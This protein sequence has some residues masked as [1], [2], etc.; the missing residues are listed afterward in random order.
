MIRRPH[1]LG[2]FPGLPEHIDWHPATR[3]KIATDAKPFRLDE[4]D[5]FFADSD[6][7]ILMEDAITAKAVEVKR[8]GLRLHEPAPRHVIDNKRGKIRLPG[9][10]A[11]RGE[12]RKREAR[13]IIGVRMRI[14]HAIEHRILR[15]C[16][17]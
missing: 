3:M 4:R 2:Q 11:N 6:R 15:R 14:G 9:D 10:R 12:F 1:A 7:T 13:D 8:Q 16:R 5:H 17:N